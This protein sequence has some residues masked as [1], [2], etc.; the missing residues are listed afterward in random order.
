MQF[1]CAILSSASCPAL[2]Y[3]FPNCLI[4]GTICEK[5]T[6]YKMYFDLL[7]KFVWKVFHHKKKWARCGHKCV[8]VFVQSTRYYCQVLMKIDFSRQIFEKYRNIKFHE[9]P[10]SEAESFYGTDRQ[11]QTDR[12]KN[13]ANPIVA[14][15]SFSKAPKMNIF[16]PNV[17]TRIHRQKFRYF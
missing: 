8:L 9:N 10:L 13:M 15:R 6:E 12:R 2:Q 16:T 3:F 14:F 1:A 4:N 5:K 17:V 7:Y 11:T